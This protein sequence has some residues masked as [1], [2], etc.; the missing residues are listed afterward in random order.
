VGC[1]V[2]ELRYEVIGLGE[3]TLT[4]IQEALAK[5]GLSL[6]PGRPFKYGRPYAKR[7]YRIRVLSSDLSSNPGRPAPVQRSPTGR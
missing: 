6:L 7:R 1:S 3:G 4:E 2:D 5:V